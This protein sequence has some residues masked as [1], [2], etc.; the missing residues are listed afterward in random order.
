MHWPEMYLHR[1]E[2]NLYN[3]MQVKFMD[4]LLYK[5][6]SIS[7]VQCSAQTL[8]TL[9]RQQYCLVAGTV[10]IQLYKAPHSIMYYALTALYII[11][12]HMSIMCCAYYIIQNEKPC[13]MAAK[14]LT[15]G[16]GGAANAASYS[17]FNNP[18][19][20]TRAPDIRRWSIHYNICS[21]ACHCLARLHGPDLHAYLRLPL[22]SY[23]CHVALLHMHVVHSVHQLVYHMRLKSCLS[24]AGLG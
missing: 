17:M 22:P 23:L 5:D 16:E 2:I 7:Y 10:V 24:T 9:A 20:A 14:H 11:G 8:K 12:V 1:T 15:Q 3:I 4:I 19:Y 18:I 21:T 6:L 13:C